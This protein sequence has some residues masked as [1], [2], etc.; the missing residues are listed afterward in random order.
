MMQ[1]MTLAEVLVTAAHLHSVPNFNGQPGF[2]ARG[3]RLWAD[4]HGM[5]WSRFVQ[6]GVP[7]EQ[8]E[9]TGDA[10]ALRLAAHA[11]EQAEPAAAGGSD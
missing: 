1:K 2:C 3:A 11:R 8:L 9:A 6:H 10:M 7:A 4:A 5:D